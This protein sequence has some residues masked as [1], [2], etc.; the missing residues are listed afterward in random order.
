MRIGR[1]SL[2]ALGKDVFVPV[3][4]EQDGVAEDKNEVDEEVKFE[5]VVADSL[6]PV[7]CKFVAAVRLFGGNSLKLVLLAALRML[8]C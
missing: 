7:D 3:G 8:I 5:V 6:P 1:E 4:S 2:A